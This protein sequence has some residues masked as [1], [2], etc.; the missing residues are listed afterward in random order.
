[1]RKNLLLAIAFLLPVFS[2]AQDAAPAVTIASTQKH[3]LKSDIAG[4]EYELL[5]HLPGNYEQQKEK[6]YPVLY[7]LDAQWDFPLVTGLYGSQYYDGFIPGLIIVGITWGGRDPNPGQLLFRDFTPA[8]QNGPPGTG[9]AEKFLSFIKKELIPYIDSKFRTK[10]DDRVLVGSSLGGLFTLYALYSDPSLFSRYILTSPALQWGNSIIQ[11][12]EK[13]Y[14]AKK[15]PLKAKLFMAHGELENP[16]PFEIFAE[17]VRSRNYEGL[18]MQTRIL[19]NTGHSGTKAE[20][21]ARGLQW[22]F[23]RPSLELPAETL[24]KYVGSYQL[25]NDTLRVV[26]GR[27]KLVGISGNN[28]FI[29][30]AETENDFYFKGQFLNLHF[31]KGTG[32]IEGFQMEQ[33]EGSRFVKKISK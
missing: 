3:S 11:E 24:N 18:D 6:T 32:K 8:V 28:R 10:K 22:V 4:Q 17:R 20:G 29:L 30:E 33:F 13:V 26:A 5:I 7:L 16:G 19:D 1:M 23:A 31:P 15:I 21:Y 14:A 9:N 25:G 12:Y 2:H 27:G